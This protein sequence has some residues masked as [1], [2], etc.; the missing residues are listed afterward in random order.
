[1]A[2]KFT[3]KL[4]MVLSALAAGGCSL[5]DAQCENKVLRTIPSPGGNSSAVVFV[6][7]CGATTVESLQLSLLDAGREPKDKGNVL[8]ADGIPI[9]AE[10][11]DVAWRDR[12]ELVVKIPKDARIFLKNESIGTVHVDFSQ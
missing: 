11:I 7:G 4:M 6:R 9:S 3:A 12:N 5:G 10:G 1:M 2:A 8:I